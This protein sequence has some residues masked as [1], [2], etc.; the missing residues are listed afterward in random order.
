MNLVN[1]KNKDSFFFFINMFLLCF[2]WFKFE[3]KNLFGW[4]E[5]KG[6]GRENKWIGIGESEVMVK[7]SGVFYG[8]RILG[9]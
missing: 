7:K 8:W 1:F 2:E 5:V 3:I 6:K 9:D 4:E